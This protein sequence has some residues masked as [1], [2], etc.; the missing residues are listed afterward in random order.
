M[1]KITNED[2]RLTLMVSLVHAV[3]ANLAG[4]K[5]GGA[6]LMAANFGG[7]YPAGTDLRGAYLGGANLFL[8]MYPKDLP[9]PDGWVRAGSGR[10]VLSDEPAC[11]A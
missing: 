10:L 1:K 5:F 11:Q 2:K 9:A 8:A 3:R 6:N 7:T 4:T